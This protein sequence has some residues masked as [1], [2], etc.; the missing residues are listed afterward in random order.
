MGGVLPNNILNIAHATCCCC[1]LAQRAFV[2]LSLMF[3][4]LK[5]MITLVNNWTLMALYTIGRCV[6]PTTND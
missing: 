2:A 1:C 3:F 6:H 5:A 4:I